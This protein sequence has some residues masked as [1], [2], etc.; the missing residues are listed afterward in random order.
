[1][2]VANTPI[3]RKEATRMCHSNQESLR[4]QVQFLRRQFLQDGDLPFTNVLTEEVIAQ[5]LTA[6]TGWLDRVFSPLVTLWV[7]LGQVLGADHSCRAAVARLIAHRLAEG[8]RPCSAET[9]AYCQA[10]KRLPESFFADVACQTGRALEANADARWLWK[11]RHV[12]L[13]DGTTVTMPDTRENQQAYPQVYNQKPGLGFPIAR[14]GAL[15]SLA[16]GA[17]VN[18]GFCQYAGKGQGEVSLLRRLWDSLR[19]GDVLLTDALLGN[20]ANL[21]MLQARGVE[22]VGRLNKA[23]RK[24]DFRRGQR[25]G[26]DDHVVQWRKPTSIRSLDREAYHALPEFITVRETRIR[27]QQP[28]FRTRSIV[29]VTTLLDPEQTTKEDL[30]TLY[31]ARWHNELDLRSLK[32]AMQMRELRCKTPE[33]VR[34]EVWAHILAYNLIRT[35]MAQAAAR[36]GVEP[37]SIS[38]TG[39]MQTLEAF[40]PL[41]EFGAT[42]DAAGRLRLYHDLLDAIATHRVGDRPDRYEPRREKAETQSLRL[43]DQA[44]RR[45]ETQDG[46]RRYQE[47]SAI[48]HIDRRIGAV[49]ATSLQGYSSVIVVD[50]LLAL[51]GYSA[52]GWR[53][54]RSDTRHLTETEGVES[55][56]LLVLLLPLPQGLEVFG[57]RS[58]NL[59]LHGREDDEGRVPLPTRLGLED[60]LA[61]LLQGDRYRGCADQRPSRTP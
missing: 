11:G 54:R 13:F 49:R 40:Q 1:M 31:R 46:E 29:V 5:A 15:I 22:L 4:Q 17:V 21:V 58:C 42:Q 52:V 12:Y 60:R 7:F 44:P 55:S 39:A 8:Q 24:A 59:G 20:W 48:R 33:L 61:F 9:G 53:S 14:L 25:L 56:A 30:A 37:R 35:V 2:V 28:G 50:A 38:F 3:H 34:K 51:D 43:A 47:L 32:S 23:H 18:L 57:S 6:V 10:R 36:H 41:L 16:C 27:V 19:P 45:D 26:Q